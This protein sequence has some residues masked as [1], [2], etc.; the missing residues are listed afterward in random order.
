MSAQKSPR[1]SLSLREIIQIADER[2]PDGLV[3]LYHHEPGLDHGD[4]LAL[5]IVRELRDTFEAKSPASVQVLRAADCMERAAQEL[6][7]LAA[8]FRSK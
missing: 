6:D 7:S 4:T 8:A 1:K 3:G 5:F 2:Y